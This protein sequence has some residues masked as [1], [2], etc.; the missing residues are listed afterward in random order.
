MVWKMNSVADDVFRLL[1]LLVILV[2]EFSLLSSMDVKCSPQRAFTLWYLC[3]YQSLVALQVLLCMM[4][5]CLRER[6]LLLLMP[7]MLL[8]VMMEGLR[9]SEWWVCMKGTKARGGV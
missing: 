5:S 2:L 6:G 1:I 9:L 4:L 8:K 7:W 3:L